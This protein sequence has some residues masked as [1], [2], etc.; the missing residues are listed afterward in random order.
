MKRELSPDVCA[1][2]AASRPLWFVGGEDQRALA[3]V[4]LAR[5]D[6]GA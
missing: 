3:G 6:R 5:I 4:T 2:S 1:F